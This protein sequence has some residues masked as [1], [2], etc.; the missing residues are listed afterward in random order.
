VAITV[1]QLKTFLAVVDGG[2]VTAAADELVVTQPS[3]SSAISSLGRELGCELF[4]RSGRGVELTAAGAAFAPYAADVVGLLSSGRQAAREASEVEAR[5]LRLIAVTTAAESFVPPLMRAFSD[6][7]PEIG[8]T[9]DVGNRETVLARIDNHE[10]DVAILGR[11]PA[12]ERLES[13]PLI[14]NEIVCIA[15]PDDPAVGR[16]AVS[17]AELGDRSWLLREPGSGTRALNERFLEEQG[18]TPQTLTL[19]SNGAIRQ[20]A[21]AGL[22][23]SLVSRETVEDELE[24]GRLGELRLRDR[25]PPRTWFVVRSAVGPVREVVRSFVGFASEQRR[26]TTRSAPASS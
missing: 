22:G 17:A 1:A 26:P 14:S 24:S 7:H 15:A 3:V 4:Q 11:P 12:D 5:R 19:G 16:T 10:A 13:L 6:L 9:L 8:L 23:V 25:P 21:R 18:I 2:S 20:A